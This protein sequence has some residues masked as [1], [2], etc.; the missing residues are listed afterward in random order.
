L[1]NFLITPGNV[2]DITA[3]YELGDNLHDTILVA[4]K[5]YDSKR[6][7]DQLRQNSNKPIIPVR[8]TNTAVE[9]FNSGYY[10]KRHR[11]ENFF[12]RIKRFRRLATRYEKTKNSF[13]A[14]LLFA[15]VLDWIKLN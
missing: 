6:F 8:K 14:F 5:A 10:K 9:P 11:V 1:L 12:G 13:E 15:S 7:R 4:D 2:N 3:A